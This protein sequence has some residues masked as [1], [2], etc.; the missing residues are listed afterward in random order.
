MGQL[1]NGYQVVLRA[2]ACSWNGPDTGVEALYLWTHC[3]LHTAH[4]LTSWKSVFTFL[5]PIH[6][7]CLKENGTPKGVVLLGDVAFLE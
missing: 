2:S 4:L 3:C 5:R 6:C 1:G 7:G